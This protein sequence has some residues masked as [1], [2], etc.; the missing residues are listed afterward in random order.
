MKLIKRKII[1]ITF[2]VYTVTSYSQVKN[3]G[4]PDIRNYSKTAYKGGT[5]NWDIN[6]DSNGNIYFANN[7]GLLQF[8]GSSW[9]T[10]NLPNSSE[11]KTVKIDASGKI[12][13]GGYNEFG[14]FE[15]NDKGKMIYFSLS[16]LVDRKKIKVTDFVWKIHLF[17]DEVIFQTFARCYIYKKNKIKVIEAP[18]RFQFSYQVKNH[19]YI[20]DISTGIMEYHN[21]KL[22]PLKGSEILNNTE[23]W[24]MF[25]LPNNKILIATLDKGLFLYENEKVYPWQTE[26]NEFIKKFSSLGGTNIKND[27]IVLNT[28]LNGMIICNSDGKI[29]QHVNYIKGLQNNTVLS[30][31]VDKDYNL[32]L[33]LD[34]GI[35]YINENSPFTY[36]GFSYNLGTVYGSVI[37]KNYLYVATNQGVFYHPWN[38]SFKEETFKLVNGTNAQAWSVQVIDNQLLCGSNSGAL[39]IDKGKLIKNLD[40]NGYFS[41]KKIPNRPNFFIGSYYDGFTIFE[42][43][44]NSL[45]FRNKVEGSSD[46]SASSFELDDAN[47]W[48]KKDNFLYK[49]ELSEDLKRFKTIKKYQSLLK[50]SPGI[51]CIQKIRNQVYFVRENHFFKYSKE[52]NLFF[53]DNEI[54][55]LFEKIPRVNSLKEDEQGNIWYVFK[56]SLGVLMKSKT[57]TYYNNVVPF[58]NLTGNLV[59]NNI[60][61]NT[62]NSNN[63]FIGLTDGLAHYDSKLVDTYVTKPKSYIRNVIYAGDT[64]ILKNGQKKCTEIEIPYVSNNVKFTFSTPTFENLENV[65]Y[66]YNL[67]CFDESWS[68]WSTVSVKEYTNLLEGNYNMQV[69]VRNSYGIQSDVT[70]VSFKILRPW[71]RTYL[72][73]LCYL[74]LVFL[75]IYFTTRQIKFKIRKNKYYETIEQRRLYLE[76]ETKIKQEQYELEKE[77]ERLENEKLQIKILSK[78][79]ELVNNTL[80]VVKKNKSLNGIISKLKDIDTNS[81][82]ESTKNQISKLNKSIVKEV[83]TDKSWKDLEKHIKNVHFDFLKKLKDKHPT[84]SP[85]E[86]DLS[87]YLLMNMSTK[88]IAEFMSISTAGVE[89]ARYRLRKKLELNKKENLIGYLMNI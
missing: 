45:E 7:E 80:Q 78:D 56:E 2:L 82:D 54:S 43:T 35:A 71:Y 55:N 65:E 28:V 76:K 40:N 81:F 18:K 31:F 27:F 88:E 4:L 6:Q 83:N 52:Q 69:K 39:V 25:S 14:Y 1:I 84:I 36:F 5:Q 49:M 46:R 26:A 86:M 12:F 51:D 23:V 59:K 61:I 72:A 67:E 50:S 85:R 10:Y 60:S 37:H 19:L 63:I 73:Y 58:S 66:S 3:I 74:L 17:K 42:K 11:I 24:G 34:N 48:V 47:V 15:A 79:K 22:T 41:F 64:L 8:D 75:G 30:S 77:I 89:L 70:G 20:Q 57:G 38:S 32:W 53:E 9:R 29:I 33:G 62:I 68:R 16:K 13:V 21:N 44:D 87:T